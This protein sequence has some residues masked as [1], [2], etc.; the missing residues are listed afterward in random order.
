MHKKFLSLVA[1]AIFMQ[2]AVAQT[3]ISITKPV[4]PI[5]M[6]CTQ[7]CTDFII[8]V[9]GIHDNT[10]YAV[11]SIAYNPFPFINANTPVGF[12]DGEDGMSDTIVL[13]FPFALYDS[14]YDKMVIAVDGFITFNKSLAKTSNVLNGLGY[15]AL[16][17]TVF[18][19][20][21]TIV[22]IKE[23]LWLTAPTAISTTKIDTITIGSAPCRKFVISWN[24]IPQRFCTGQRVTAQIVLYEGSNRVETYIKN[25]SQC[26]DG[27][28]QSSFIMGMQNWDRNAAVAPPGRSQST[29]ALSN[30]AWGYT[31]NGTGFLFEGSQ[32]FVGGTFYGD[33]DIA[34]LGTDSLTLTFYEVCPDVGETLVPH[35]ITTYKLATNS[36]QRFVLTDSITIIKS[37]CTPLSFTSQ[38]TNPTCFG[39]TNGSVI[40]H[41]SGGTRPYT[42][43]INGTDYFNDSTFTNLAAGTYTLYTKDN[44][45]T[46]VTS[47]AILTSPT[48]VV[49]TTV[50]VNV[51]CN[52]ASTGS[53]T[54]TAS[55]GTPGY[56]YSLNGGGYQAS[57]V[58]SGLAANTYSIT[59]KDANNCTGTISATVTQ[60]AAI[61]ATTTNVNVL[62]FGGAT[63]SI[64]VN[65]SG[66]T[67]GYQYNL[68]G[69]TYQGSNVFSGLTAT[70]YTV[71][72]K[73][74]NNCTTTVFASIFQPEQA[75]NATVTTVNNVC[76]GGIAG[77]I[78][79]TATGGAPGYQ[80]AL[81][82]G[83]FQASNVFNGLAAGT[84]SV[85]ARDVN[86]CAKTISNIVI[87]EPIALTATRVFAN[88][89][90][91]GG[92][93]GSITITAVGGTPGYQY[94]LNGGP[95]QG[96]NVFAGLVAAT[97]SVTVRDANNCSTSIPG[98]VV[99]QPAAVSATT[100]TQGAG[101]SI[102]PSGSITVTASGGTSPYQYALNG[103]VYQSS[104]VFSGLAGATYSISVRDA[105]SC[106]F[107]TS[108]TVG[109]SFNLTVNTINDA[110]ICAGTSIT[111]TTVSNGTSFSWSPATGLNSSIAQSPTAS[112]TTFTQYIVTASLG[113]CSA[114]D[115]VNISVNPAP[116]VN[117][118]GDQTVILGDEATIN[119]T[120]SPGI[121]LWTPATGL[122][123]TN[124]LST[125]AKPTVTTPYMLRVTTDQGCTATDEV[126]INVLVDC[127]KPVNVFT[128]NGDG[129]NDTW[130]V[131]VGGNCT[132]SVEV[133]VFNRNGAIVYQSKNYSNSWDG[134]YSGKGLPD[135]TYYWVIQ[136]V[137]LTSR[138]VTAKGN[139]TILR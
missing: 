134:T 44:S 78:T 82:G 87:T 14:A 101:C 129:I 35:I 50:V 28:G 132:K 51:L 97:Y 45:G 104:N 15:P 105:N 85:T 16:P 3:C 108:A 48:A 77:S 74:A 107:S 18:T 110:T 88:V 17:S 58:F 121:Y 7:N 112:P 72:I 42:F 24:D 90:C 1:L 94:S 80:Y 103:G 25:R 65:A 55:G 30:E 125:K 62:C 81:N 117:A 135:G 79:V 4:D 53:V 69:G 22:T 133:T 114:K 91:F 84:Y 26:F 8:K 96:S 128:P 47:S 9:P 43:S 46:I 52:G 67:P 86:G 32:L 99:S 31:P 49:G 75:L 89:L 113:P 10:G 136:Y 123:S 27:E 71:G 66:G 20:E 139:V 102:L 130:Q 57:N 115:T 56:Q 34:P 63:G 23:D 5:L 138:V 118:G 21:A 116:A 64:T 39:G 11:Q 60:P 83:T 98:I 36:P 13:P 2:T 59:I 41:A 137:Y 124:T 54:I 95:Y 73:D 70:T 38:L 127:V 126:I 40:I 93:T 111:L 68:N 61:T 120:A 131:T 29:V 92:N 106:T 76:N 100:V 37:A 33:A 109:A 122:S 6:P 12:L 19:P 119:A